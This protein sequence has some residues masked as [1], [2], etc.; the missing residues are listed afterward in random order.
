MD[1]TLLIWQPSAS[2]GV[3]MPISKIGSSGGVLGGSVG[4]SLLG[5]TCSNW[6]GRDTIVGVAYGGSV[7]IW[8]CEVDPASETADDVG[9]RWLQVSHVTGHFGAVKDITWPPCGSYLM[10]CSSDQTTR[11]WGEIERG[12]WVEVGRP[13]VHGYELVQIA[14]IGAGKELKHRFVSGGDEKVIRAFD[15]PADTVRR[16]T[17]KTTYVPEE[18][19]DDG[20]TREERAFVPALGLSNKGG[21]VDRLKDDEVDLGDPDTEAQG[22]LPGERDLGITTLWLEVRKLLGHQGEILSLES[23]AGCKGRSESGSP[24]VVASTCKARDA[25]TAAIRIWNVDEATCTTVLEGGH[26]SSVT[27][28]GF[29]KDGRRLASSGKDRCV[30][31]WEI[32]IDVV[33]NSSAPPGAMIA[34]IENAHKRIVWCLDWCKVPGKED[35]LATG[36]R[37]GTVK[38]WKVGDVSSPGMVEVQS[39]SFQRQSVTAIAFAPSGEVI[40]IGFES[41]KIMLMKLESDFAS[42]QVLTEEI[43]GGHKSTVKRLRWRPG[44][45]EVMTLASCGL[46]NAVR[47]FE[48]FINQM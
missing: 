45:R 31:I 27:S 33:V 30:C 15:A 8:S 39:I 29:A 38:I 24:V 22:A 4:N 37:D 1:R 28:L 21:D 43:E 41:G 40:A 25:D 10:S 11:I 9:T 42:N 20:V 16:L 18:G 46:D 14:A 26:K 12:R 5:F 13:Q 6:L 35:Y 7:G 19:E 36:S 2:S 23:N 32:N 47:I 17:E 34:K 48:V 3:W 44:E